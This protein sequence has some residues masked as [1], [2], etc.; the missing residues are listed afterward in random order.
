MGNNT[1]EEVV[2]GDV[3]K[4]AE[5]TGLAK[6]TLDRMRVLRPEESPPFLR[7]GKRVIYPLT[8]PNGLGAWVEQRVAQATGVAR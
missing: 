8:G 3:H 4:V 7:I 2:F 5:I 6:Y 1:A